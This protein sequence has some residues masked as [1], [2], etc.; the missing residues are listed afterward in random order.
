MFSKTFTNSRLFLV[1]KQDRIISCRPTVNCIALGLSGVAA[2]FLAWIISPFLGFSLPLSWCSIFAAALG[3]FI[4]SIK[5]F[6][7]WFTIVTDSSIDRVGHR[8]IRLSE[9]ERLIIRHWLHVS[10]SQHGKGED[11]FIQLCVAYS[12][13]IT[14]I[15]QRFCRTIREDVVIQYME[16]AIQLASRCS[17][18]IEVEATDEYGKTWLPRGFDIEEAITIPESI[19]VAIIRHGRRGRITRRVVGGEL[20]V[21]QETKT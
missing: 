2:G 16:S 19:Q 1:T 7:P 9:I 5:R 13:E 11:R 12:G 10:R 20:E 4:F 15:Q 18:D 14:P 3:G 21:L 8:C 6:R 17:V